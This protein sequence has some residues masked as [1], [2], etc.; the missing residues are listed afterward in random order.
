M[1][2]APVAFT[3]V[4]SQSGKE[5]RENQCCCG[6]SVGNKLERTKRTMKE[7]RNVPAW[8]GVMKFR[9]RILH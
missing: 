4:L 9:R 1:Y 8:P 7:E 6:D 2:L 3:R 5:R